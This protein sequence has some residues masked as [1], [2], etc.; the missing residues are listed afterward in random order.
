VTSPIFKTTGV[1]TN[2]IDHVTLTPAPWLTGDE[3]VFEL[4]PGGSTL[5]CASRSFSSHQAAIEPG[6]PDQSS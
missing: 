6:E 1:P 5:I 2:A 3:N 4:C